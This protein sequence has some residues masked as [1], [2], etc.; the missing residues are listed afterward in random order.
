MKTSVKT[1]RR[2]DPEQRREALLSFGCQHF[3]EHSFDAISMDVMA[4]SA[5]VSKALLYHYFKGRRGFY[6]ATV[7]HVVDEVIVAMTTACADDQDQAILSMLTAFVDYCK[8][9]AGIYKTVIRG[10]LGADSDVSIETN[11]VRA[12]VLEQIATMTGMGALTPLAKLSLRGWIAMVETATAEW[13]D[14]A[15][16]SR[17]EFINFI[18]STLF[19]IVSQIEKTSN[20]D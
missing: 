3:S 2:L 9:N 12:F 1:R 6:L 8:E 14:E 20:H 16:V 7:K 10:G 13:I 15:A 19:V 4:K 5:G 17:E 11:R 18:V